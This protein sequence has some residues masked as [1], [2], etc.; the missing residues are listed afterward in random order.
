[1]LG[2]HIGRDPADDEASRTQM[3]QQIDRTDGQKGPYT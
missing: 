1:M 2:S 3:G